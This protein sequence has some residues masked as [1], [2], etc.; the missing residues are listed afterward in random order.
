MP[1]QAL[2]YAGFGSAALDDW[3]Q[4]G[5]R[6]VGLQAV[7]RSASLLAFRMDDRKQRIVIDRAMPEG[8]RFLGWE[9]ADAAALDR[10]AARLEQAG[11]DVTAEPQTLADNRRV[12]GLISFHDPA[13]NRLEAFYGADIDATPFRP[14]RSISGFRTGPLG[15]GHAVLTVENIDAVM[16]FYVD[17]LGFGLSDYMQKPFRAYFFHINAR[18]H[19]LALI[20]T[21][22]N[23][24]HHLMVEMFS[25][26]DVGQSYDVALSETDRI[27][28]TLGRHT[29]D[30]MTSFYAKTPSSFMVECGWGGRE[31]EPSSWQPFEL[32]DGPS[33]WGHERVWLPPADRE[34]ARQMR[35]R[36]AAAG[37]RAPVQVMDGNYRLMSGTC[38]W[39][40]G[41][42]KTDR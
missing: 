40:D 3:R 23:G 4:F 42:S 22:R 39:W 28:V 27:G 10:L 6:L 35:M 19:S 20:E 8:S 37:L 13:G 14:G 38:A 36:A 32:Q 2:G 16:P 34:V 26:D 31:I 21:G 17:L 15:L 18:H 11:V 25:L 41:V 30:L 29:N 7:E 33:L 5:T 12:R 1:L 9:V 24:M